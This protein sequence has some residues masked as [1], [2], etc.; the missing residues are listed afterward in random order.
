MLFTPGDIIYSSSAFINMNEPD[1]RYEKLATLLEYHQ[2][3]FADIER[4]LGEMKEI[5]V[6]VVG[7]TIIDE[8][9]YTSMIGGQTKIPTI[10]VL[11]NHKKIMW[12]V[13]PSS[14][15]ICSRLPRK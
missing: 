11:M 13:L 10:S 4:A 6:H 8:F 14:R 12:V 15:N 3:S 7:D 9:N 5:R 1:V 2:V